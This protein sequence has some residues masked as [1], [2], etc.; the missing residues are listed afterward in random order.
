ASR[1]ID[2]ALGRA[3]EVSGGAISGIECVDLRSAGGGVPRIRIHLLDV[4]NAAQVQ[5][6]P[7]AVG[8]GSEE[9]I[10]ARI[11]LLLGQHSIGERSDVAAIGVTP[12]VHNGERELTGRVASDWAGDVLELEFRF[13]RGVV[14][15]LDR[16]LYLRPGERSR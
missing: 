14:V 7:S 8:P 16:D 15:P 4:E 11:I 6:K 10:R 1:R 3:R 5:L 12:A 2:A 13:R 9:E